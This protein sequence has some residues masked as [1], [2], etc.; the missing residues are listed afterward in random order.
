MCMFLQ[1]LRITRKFHK[2]SSTTGADGNLT[3]LDLE[4]K[5]VMVQDKDVTGDT[6]GSTARGIQV[7]GKREMATCY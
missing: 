2:L 1:K 4:I 6:V 3:Q 5:R 7:T